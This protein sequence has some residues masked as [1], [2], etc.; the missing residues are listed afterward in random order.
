MWEYLTLYAKRDNG[1]EAFFIDNYRERGE[2]V[3]EQAVLDDLGAEGWELV[4]VVQAYTSN[5][6]SYNHQLYF[7]RPQASMPPEQ[8]TT[9][10]DRYAR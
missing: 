2:R 4:A 3:S 5:S 8:A 10:L 6:Q 7:K 9:R 1:K